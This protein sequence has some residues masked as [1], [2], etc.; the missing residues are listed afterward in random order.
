MG[1]GLRP[2]ADGAPAQ[3]DGVG[4][5]AGIDIHE[6]SK[7][8]QTNLP[9]A[10]FDIPFRSLVPLGVENL[11]TAG[12]CISGSFLAHASYRVTGD[13]LMMGEAAGAKACEAI[14]RNISVRQLARELSA[15]YNLEDG[16]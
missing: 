15:Q 11:L 16:Q 5:K 1:H 3:P 8:E 12:R 9:N 2:I 14:S 13:C 4:S 6:P 10:G 7:A